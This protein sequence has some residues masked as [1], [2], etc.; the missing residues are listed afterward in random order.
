M[1]KKPYSFFNLQWILPMIFVVLVSCSANPFRGV[2]G[3]YREL[4]EQALSNA[5]D[6]SGE[7][8]KALTEASRK[9]K[10][11]VAF[12]ISYMPERDLQSL[13]SEFILENVRYALKARNEFPW[14]RTLPDSI[15]LNEVLPYISLNERR[16]NWRADFYNRFSPLVRNCKDIREAID[17][18]NINIAALLEVEYNTKRKK[19]DQSPYESMEIGM[20]SCSGLSILLTDAFR[21]V[22]IPSRIAGTP[23]WTNMRGNHSWCELWID[24]EWYFT[25]Y[26]PDKLN[27]SW[28]LADAG[29]ADPEKPVHWVYASSFKPTGLSYPLVW[30]R[31]I[32]Y[33]P[34]ENVTQ[35]YIELYRQQMAN[36]MPADDE[37]MLNVVLYRSADSKDGNDRVISRVSVSKG[38]ERVDFGYTPGPRDDM[39]RFLTFRLKKN[40]DYHFSYTD[41]E[42][43][44]ITVTH[45]TAEIPHE[46]LRLNYR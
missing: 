28:F 31:S 1:Y 42:G 44:T 22:G 8:E 18:V 38:E 3:Q 36:T 34:A 13:T 6:N 41:D 7:L 25:E 4:L 14:S 23:L 40:T 11:A 39:N 20:A 19:A 45:N 33:V 29:K 43:E 26:Y 24:G 2:P 35:R 46:L 9:E 5:G 21:A 16:D 27:Q 10:E 17:S 32:K 15:F 12:L 37:L 30:D